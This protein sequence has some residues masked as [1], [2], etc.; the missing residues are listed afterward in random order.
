MHLI[1][2]LV[3][4]GLM[5][6]Q[7]TVEDPPPA[8]DGPKGKHKHNKGQQSDDDIVA[9]LLL[10]SLKGN[11]EIKKV[12][13]RTGY[14]CPYQGPRIRYTRACADALA[15]PPRRSPFETSSPASASFAIRSSGRSAP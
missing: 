1:Q 7:K 8:K 11:V 4:N 2:V 13:V 3:F 10:G 6:V 15:Y 14:R 5:D 9:M 12:V